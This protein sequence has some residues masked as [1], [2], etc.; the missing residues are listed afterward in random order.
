MSKIGW[1]VPV[2]A[3]LALGVGFG[4]GFL[5]RGNGSTDDLRRQVSSL[6]TRLAQETERAEEA[7]QAAA[8]AQEEYSSKL[9][10]LEE[11]ESELEQ[12]EAE[13]QAEVE[14]QEQTT[15]GDGIWQ[16]GTDIE[17]GTYRAPGGGSCYWALLRSADT[18]DIINNGG[19]GP[20]Q[21]LEIDSPWFETQDCG[22]WEKV[23]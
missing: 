22:E 15:F 4:V 20:N 5:I 10:E 12:L 8:D 16:V 23:G 1:K 17:P 21:T 14:R 9:A 11:R 3:V 6:Q 7:E 13:L 19:F 18:S 2:A